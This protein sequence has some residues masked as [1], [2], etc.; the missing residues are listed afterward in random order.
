MQSNST[1]P[2]L[3]N[4]ITLFGVFL[5]FSPYIILII[6][7]IFNSLGI[8]YPPLGINYLILIINGFYASIVGIILI[9]TGLILIKKNNN[10]ALQD[11][12]ASKKSLENP[13][14]KPEEGSTRI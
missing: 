14:P 11:Q 7:K 10:K 4:G 13:N 8:F 12:E 6:I 2:R 9:I 5:F 3:A 1:N